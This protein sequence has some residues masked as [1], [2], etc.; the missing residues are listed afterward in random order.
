[1]QQASK[2][3]PEVIVDKQKLSEAK[4]AICDVGVGYQT[5]LVGISV[6]FCLFALLSLGLDVYGSN[7]LT[8]TYLNVT[9]TH[10]TI[11]LRRFI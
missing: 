9:V 6:S 3:V 11:L 4:W 10:S 5:Q 8:Q 2:I 1:M 7:W